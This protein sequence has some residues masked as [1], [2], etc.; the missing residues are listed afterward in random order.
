MN[1]PSIRNPAYRSLTDQQLSE[2]DELCDRFDQELVNGR[3]PRIEIFLAETP[4]A[5]RD[6]LLAELL[7]MEFEYRT[8]QGDELEPEPEE[9]LQRFPQQESV[10]AGLFA[11]DAATP[12]PGQGTISNPVDIPTVLANLRLQIPA[13]L[14]KMASE[15]IKT[16][17]LTKQQAI[18]VIS[19]LPAAQNSQ[20]DFAKA[21]IRSNQLTKFQATAV[22]QGK[23]QSLVFGEYV[24]L[25]KIGAGG[26]GVVFHAQHRRMKR[27]V[28][29]KVL[30]DGALDD[31]DAVNRFYREVQAAAKLLHPN[32]VAAFDAG[33]HGKSHF[34]AMEFVD[35]K[36]L[37]AIVKENGPLPVATAI[38]MTIQAARGLEYAH[39]EGLVHRDIKPANL[40]V[41]KKGT[42]KILD[43]GLARLTDAVQGDDG[44]TK[45]GQIMGTVD[46]MA[47]EQAANTRT[48]DARADIYSLGCTLYR[49]LTDSPVFS[50]DTIMNKMMAHMQTPPPGLRAMRADVP[51]QLDAVYQRMLAKQPDQRQQ[52]MTEV[53]QQLRDCLDK[54][55]GSAAAIPRVPA[56]A[57]GEPASDS[58]LST[59]SNGITTDSKPAAGASST[60]VT[61]ETIDLQS[62][63]DRTA[64]FQP[65]AAT[66]QLNVAKPVTKPLPSAKRQ[67]PRWPFIAVGASLAGIILLAAVVFFI[68]STNGVI[69]V[70]IADN[71]DDP[72]VEVT[73]KG[74]TFVLKGAEKKNITLTAGEH[75][76]HV[77]RGDFEFDTKSLILKKRDQVVVKV[78]LV[79]GVVQAVDEGGNVIGSVNAT[80]VNVTLAKSESPPI[81]MA[82]FKEAQAK[83]HQKA[84]ADYLGASVETTNSIGMKFAVIPPGT[85]KMGED[86]SVVDV[87]LTKPFRLGVHEVTQGQWK[88][89]M[90]SEPWKGEERVKEGEKIA[91][92][93]INWEAAIDFCRKLTD[94]ER[95]AGRLRAD[96]EYRLPTEA[97]WE[98]ACRAGSI[99]LFTF[100]DKE[101]QFGKYAWY[102]KNAMVVDG[103]AYAHPVG[104]KKPNAWGLYDVHGNVWEW[105][106]DGRGNELPGGTDPVGP[107]Q[108]SNL[109]FRGG[110]WTMDAWYCRSPV[111]SSG[112][113][114]SLMND[115]LGFRVAQVPS[116]S[117]STPVADGQR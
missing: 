75:V 58:Q 82:P 108:G 109:V 45:S 106:G 96:Q 76:L 61:E 97:Q 42:V 22:Y 99:T 9:Y 30:P 100:G 78:Q 87:T 116:S 8:G 101:S 15:I 48:A 51:E 67:I 19:G 57:V 34:L 93:F 86:D 44:L 111:S 56:K 107:V 74:N 65:V 20:Q 53:I 115:R 88:T 38:D 37:S 13:G 92:T 24:V 17:L 104:L 80:P 25:D 31:E 68:R 103:E 71:L 43:M 14:Q 79:D 95:A 40:L 55:E 90:G 64:I 63:P 52:S 32:I 69:R 72:Q 117:A 91:A 33:Q 23:A 54:L 102:R 105:C 66:A 113:D 114:P 39:G 62:S 4:E 89:V 41:D 26:M 46:Y 70:E 7:A 16:G 21:L 77:R 73:V 2:I 18:D 81:A 94:R 3:G 83:A 10:I 11:R 36:D 50:G 110:S 59:L 12:F 28:A 85:F 47:P 35:G 84:W 6:G 1:D 98:W 29:I 5:A 60:A 49:L 112:A 27:D